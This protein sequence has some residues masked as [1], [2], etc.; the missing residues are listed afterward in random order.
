MH[1]DLLNQLKFNKEWSSEKR[2]SDP[3]Y[4][5]RLAKDQKPSILLIGCSDSRVSP[6]TILGFDPGEV[7]VHRNIANQCLCEDKNFQAILQFAVETLEISDIII[8]GHYECGGIKEAWS[9]NSEGPI[10]DW[11]LPI[12]RMI[13]LVQKEIKTQATIDEKLN[14]L[15]RK[16]ILE[17]VTN[18]RN[19]EIVKNASVQR[20]INIYPCLFDI[21]TG[22]VSV[23]F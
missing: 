5:E 14:F 4:F 23:V 17:Q 10:S 20:Q 3:D 7:F 18:I 8:M 19:S 9:G 21:H 13:S 1:K 2:K 22:L 12:K 11:I 6:S 15:T 16:N